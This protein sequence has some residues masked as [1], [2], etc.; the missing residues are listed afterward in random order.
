MLTVIS[1]IRGVNCAD[2]GSLT[3]FDPRQGR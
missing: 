3:S 1:P 2:L